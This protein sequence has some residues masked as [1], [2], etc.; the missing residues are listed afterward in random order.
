MRM[1]SLTLCVA[2]LG[3]GALLVGS[4]PRDAKEIELELPQHAVAVLVPTRGHQAR[5]VIEFTQT[6][7]GV[8]IAGT[9]RGLTPG[10][11]GFHIHEFGDLRSADGTAAGDHFNPG[12]ARHGA[13]GHE[14][15]HYGDFGNIEADDEGIANVIL[16][17]DWMKLHFVVGRALVVHA[18]ADD[19]ES[20]PSGDSGPRAGIGVIGIA[21]PR[22]A[23]EAA[24]GETRQPARR[25]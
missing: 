13:P 12:G 15:H 17:A 19:L 24:A 22:E 6:P 2:L 16:Q 10:K 4:E 21:R 7:R 8:R 25:E 20:Q 11:H 14:Q 18:E 5:G 9:I 3:A 23:R 1:I